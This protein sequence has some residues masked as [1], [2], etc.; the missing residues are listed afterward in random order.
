VG[1]H[2]AVDDT[3][4][5][6]AR[7]Q[8]RLDRAEAGVDDR[9]VRMEDFGELSPPPPRIQSTDETV[10]RSKK[11]SGTRFEGDMSMGADEVDFF[12]SQVGRSQKAIDVLENN[13]LGDEEAFVRSIQAPKKGT[14]TGNIGNLHYKVEDG[15][16]VELIGHNL[17]DAPRILR[18]AAIEESR[19]LRGFAQDELDFGG[20]PYGLLKKEMQE[21]NEGR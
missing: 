13:E 12:E 3:T 5:Q 4:A 20:D 6:K 10:D 18:Q 17:K 8:R 9:A 21:Y 15:K 2:A 7:R 11:G 19:F 1:I 14:H 16:I